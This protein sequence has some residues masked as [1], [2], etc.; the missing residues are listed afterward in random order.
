MVDRIE[1]FPEQLLQ[2]VPVPVH[3]MHAFTVHNASTL[4]KP[5]TNYSSTLHKLLINYS[6][7]SFY[8]IVNEGNDCK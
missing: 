1:C 7:Y 6:V 5:L 2:K 8:F 4:H 3:K